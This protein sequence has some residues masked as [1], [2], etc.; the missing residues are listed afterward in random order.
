MLR[1]RFFIPT[2]D[3]HDF[4]NILKKKT[5]QVQDTLLNAIPRTKLENDKFVIAF[6][7]QFFAPYGF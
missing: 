1:F 6:E 2:I 3:N 7:N 5:K 4:Q